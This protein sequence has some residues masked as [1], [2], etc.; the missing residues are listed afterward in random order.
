MAERKDLK[1]GVLCMQGAFREHKNSLERLGVQVVEIRKASDVEG[2]DGIVLP[3]GESTAIGKL[4]TELGIK[5]KLQ[6]MIECGTPVWGTCAGMILLAKKILGQ[7][8]V[9]MP[10]MDI[11]VMRNAYGRQLGSFNV[12]YVM[13]GVEG[14]I[15]M[16]FIRAP[17]IKEAGRDVEILSVVEGNVVAA[18]QGN[19]FVTSFHPE[20]TDDLR[21]HE[22]FV[23]M[24]SGIK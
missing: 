14:E 21:T 6:S 24:V 16:V 13:A 8:N 19:M 2:I 15:P 22:Y 10:V 23:D 20:L 3:G 12:D 9:H 18:R 17:Y 1:I 7:D 4:I 11:E 5:E